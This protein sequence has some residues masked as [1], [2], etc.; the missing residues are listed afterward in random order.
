MSGTLHQPLCYTDVQPP[1]IST[2]SVTEQ[3]PHKPVMKR[4][5]VDY[6]SE[7]GS[8]LECEN[9]SAKPKTGSADILG[10]SKRRQIG[11]A[12]VQAPLSA[13]A[14]TPAAPLDRNT[15]TRTGLPDTAPKPKPKPKPTSSLPPLPDHFND[16][17]PSNPRTTVND[18][19]SL[20]QG[21]QRQ[22]P[23][24][25]GNW[26]SHVYVEWDPSSGERDRLSSLVEKL[27]TEVASASQR[28]PDLEGVKIHTALRDPELPVDKPL[29]ISLSAPITLTTDNKDKFLDELTTAIKSTGVRPFMVDFSGGL[30]WYRS[31]ESTRSFLVLRVREVQ[32]T[33]STADA[34]P[35]PR[36][37]SLLEQCNKTVKSYGQPPLYDSPDM[38]CRFHVTIAWTHACPNES[39]KQLT[40]SLL[41]DRSTMNHQNGSVADNICIGFRIKA[42]KIK[43]GNYVTRLGLLDNDLGQTA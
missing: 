2:I 38:G 24:I 20:H 23:H 22:V 32:D 43:I 17:Y 14:P 41:D 12:G 35:N 29:H 30:H 7:S 9:P 40:D 19:P 26:P 21:R 34:N 18:D 16:K 5:L 15:N 8:E 39:L 3:P 13:P 37:T 28:D 10:Q 33:A 4:S 1:Q 11:D 42:V 36:L 27:Q 6:D 31:E 25:P